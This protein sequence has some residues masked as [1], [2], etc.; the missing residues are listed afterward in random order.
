VSDDPSDPAHPVVGQHLW[1][2]D[3][4]YVGC[5]DMTS[6]FRPGAT[7]ILRPEPLFHCDGIGTQRTDAIRAK[8]AGLHGYQ[9][10]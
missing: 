8:Q 5:P 2:A 10:Q 1:S 6:W 3:I 7:R 4:A 9:Y